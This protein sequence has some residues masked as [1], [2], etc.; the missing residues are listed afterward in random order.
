MGEKSKKQ[1]VGFLGGKFLPFHLGHV[2]FIVAASNMVDELYV[3]L[4]SSKNRDKQLC[5]REGIKYISDEIRFSWIGEAVNNLNNIKLI[6]IEDDQWDE[7]YDWDSGAD[8]IKKAIGKPIDFV[9]SSETTYN[10]HFKRNYPNAKHVII[11]AGRNVVSISGTNLRK[12]LYTHWDKLPEYV[13]KN[14]VKKVVIVGTESSGKSTLAKKLAKL[15]NTNFVE[16]V[17][18]KYCDKY[19]NH[20]TKEMFNL[21]AMEHFMEQEEK[22]TNSDKVLFVDTEAVV[23][24]FYLNKYFPGEKFPLIEE[25]IKIQNYDLV[26]YLEPDIEWVDDGLRFEREA[27]IRRQNN[28][29]MKKMFSERGINFVSIS[30]DY[31]E[32]FNKARKLVDGL[33]LKHVDGNGG[34]NVQ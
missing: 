6:R 4:S 12:N 23:T 22:A 28:E 25:I 17:G 10:E 24:Q 30:G 32:R 34:E 26:L 15:Y 7:N 3:I 9:F 8:M 19:S 29:E 33:F 20:L 18:R 31:A 2:Y 27:E 14:F 5:E 21:I 11:D 16:E 1:T 13:R